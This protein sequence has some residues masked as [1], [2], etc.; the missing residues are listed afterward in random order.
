MYIALGR[1]ALDAMEHL[2]VVI[3]S[4]D[5]VRRAVLIAVSLSEGLGVEERGWR[6]WEI[7]VEEEEGGGLEEMLRSLSVELTYEVSVEYLILYPTLPYLMP[8]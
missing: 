1:G 3:V 2:D 4:L 6:I 8:C 5:G 7:L